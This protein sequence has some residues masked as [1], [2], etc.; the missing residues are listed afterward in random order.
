MPLTIAAVDRFGRS[1][2]DQRW[3]SRRFRCLHT[4]IHLA[5]NWQCW[6]GQCD[7]QSTLRSQRQTDTLGSR[8]TPI[9]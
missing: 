6:R 7:R 4:I 9:E 3:I 5:P 8:L 2:N 1:A